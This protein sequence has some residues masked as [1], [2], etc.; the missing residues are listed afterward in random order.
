MAYRYIIIVISIFLSLTAVHGKDWRDIQK[1]FKTKK[2]ELERKGIPQNYELNISGKTVKSDGAPELGMNVHIFN[3]KVAENLKKA[4]IKYIRQTI[5]WYAFQKTSKGG[6]YSR[7]ALKKLDKLVGLY[8]K[9]ELHPVFVVHGNPPGISWKNRQEGYKQFA[10]FMKM[11]ASR[12]KYVKHWQ[13]WNE[14]DSA[15]T[16]LFG[17]PNKIPMK[18]RG[19]CYAEMLKLAYPVIKQANPEALVLTGGVVNWTQFPQGIYEA[20]GKDFFDIMCIHTYGIPLPWSFV[21]RGN[22]L[23][24]IMDAYGDTMKPLWN[25]EYGVNAKALVQ[26]WGIP[27][28]NAAKYYDDKQKAMI[29]N[30]IEFNR[31]SGLYQKSFP[32]VYLGEAEC[33]GDLR[34]KIEASLPKGTDINNYGFGLTRWDDSYRPAYKYIMTTKPNRKNT[35]KR[36]TL[37]KNDLD[38]KFTAVPR[39][40]IKNGQLQKG[41]EPFFPLGFVFG[42]SDKGLIQA[43]SVGM[44][45][46]HQE[47]SIINI[48]PRSGNEISEKGLDKIKALH[49]RATKH[50]MTFFPLLNGHYIPHWLGKTAGNSPKDI[51]G[52]KVGLWFKHS[53]HNPV[54]R[55][56]LAKFWQVIAKNVGEDPNTGAFVT[57]NEPAYGLDATPDALKVYRKAMAKKFKSIADFNRTMNTKFASFQDINPPSQPDPNRKFWYE[58]FCYNQQAYADFFSWQRKIFKKYA[59]DASLSGKHPVSV[60]TGDAMR[61]NDIVLQAASQDIY[62]CDAYNGSLFHYRDVMETARSLNPSGPVI[63]YETHGQKGIPPV[64][65]N[66]AALQMFVQILGGCRGLF[67][68]AYGKIP[69]FGFF[70]DKATP[71]KVRTAY[72]RLFKLINVNQAVFAAPRN[73]AKIAVL[74]SNPSTIHYGSNPEN[75][76]KDEY[77]KRLSQTYD[78]IRNQHF[79]VDFIAD[80]QLKDKLNHYKLLVVPSL[81]ILTE[82]DLAEVAKFHRN[83]GK[84]LAFSKAFDRDEFFNKCKIPAFLGINK[85]EPAPWNRGQMRLVEVVPELFSAFRTEIIVQAPERVNP[86]PMKQLI[87]GYIPDTNSEKHI[88]LA[89]NQDAYPSIIQSTDKQVVYCAFDSLYSEG[90]SSLLG[91]IIEKCLNFKREISAS[92]SLSGS[93]AIELMTSVSENNEYKVYMFANCGPCA[94]SWQISLAKIQNKKLYD[95][96]GQT[97]YYAE[98]GKFTLSL[99]GYGY[100]V[101]VYKK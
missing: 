43:K 84:I 68:F 57:W 5:Y 25:T 66:H 2:I 34:K 7:K 78:L 11:L 35:G 28:S 79:A 33:G 45:S 17:A 67:F 51:N 36:R 4:G 53:I 95:I 92:N 9:Y 88:C 16:D 61:C 98:S 8:K 6:R 37:K 19:K 96:A 54:F 101:L 29:E 18:E 13:L 55:N 97:D 27:K 63:T 100:A 31:K 32:Y 1:E 62:G 76:L 23:R 93:Q 64:K 74:L 56:H 41:F 82:A 73:E 12:Y 87:P 86:V 52:E 58:W 42:G 15:F 72:T 85:R 83:G 14:M 10:Q 99:P 91:G 59:P 38:K 94:G 20:G 90:L 75:S 44:N 89:A 30:C 21:L 71:P 60:L 69:G 24:D 81:S 26:A 70:S 49:Q 50:E 77:T 65:P 22:T 46:L 3:D 40:H 80:R 39:I 48:F 47:Y